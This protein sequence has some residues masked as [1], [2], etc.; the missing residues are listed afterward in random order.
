MRV[1]SAELKF[2]LEG[3]M[4]FLVS[5]VSVPTHRGNTTEAVGEDRHDFR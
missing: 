1:K 4:A 5:L 2:F 3:F